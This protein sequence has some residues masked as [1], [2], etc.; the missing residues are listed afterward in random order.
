MKA[1]IL[2]L[3]LLAGPALAQY[4]QPAAPPIDPLLEYRQCGAPVRL[5]DG[6]IRR[7]SDVL[8]A[9]K[10]L[11]P[12]P[13]TGL[14]SGACPGWSVDHTVSLVCGGCDS[15]SNLAWLPIVL[16][17]G[18]GQYPKDRWERKVYCLPRALV[19]MPLSGRLEVI[20]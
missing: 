15:V 12:C 17:A 18:A 11:H 7:R 8:Y 6:T 13:S 14:H 4:L 9:F 10:K 16:K 2:L 19:P 20:P 1:L 3:T 5:A